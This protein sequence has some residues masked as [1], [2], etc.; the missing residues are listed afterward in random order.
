MRKGKTERE[1]CKIFVKKNNPGRL[2]NYIYWGSPCGRPGRTTVHFSTLSDPD[3]SKKGG[4]GL[5]W[6]AVARWGGGSWSNPKVEASG[7]VEVPDL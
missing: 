1:T 7:V 6:R 2:S 5:S 3:V 4:F